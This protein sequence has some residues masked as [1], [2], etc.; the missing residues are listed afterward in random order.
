MDKVGDDHDVDDEREALP[1]FSRLD[2]VG[3]RRYRV[4]NRPTAGDRNR[5]RFPRQRT[6]RPIVELLGRLIEHHGL[7]DEVRQ[8]CVCIYWPEIVGERIASKAFPVSFATGIVQVSATNSSWVHELHFFKAQLI[9]KIN[10]WV[11]VNRAWLGPSPLVVDMRFA[12]AMNQRKPF[13]DREQVRRLRLDHARRATPR[14]AA[15]PP[16][17]SDADR[18]A[19]RAE[20]STIVD[21]E[22]RALIESVRLKWNR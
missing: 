5:D 14:L 2:W 3:E 15:S 16:M 22:L 12:L 1:A 13:V 11:E 9:A 10:S 4:L 7:T 20:T 6:Q 8:R 18:E 17:A 19:I 21:A